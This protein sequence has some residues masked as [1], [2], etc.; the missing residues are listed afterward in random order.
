MCGLGEVDRE[1]L[2][3]L[4]HLGAEGKLRE[5]IIRLLATG[6]LYGL[7][8]IVL[9]LFLRKS[10]GRQV[11]LCALG[12]LVLSVLFGKLINQIVA[13]DRPFVVFPEDVRHVGLFVRP[14]SFPS[15][16]AMAGFGIA[17]G[18]LFGRYWRWGLIMVAISLFMIASRVAAGIHWPSDVVGGGLMGV[19]MA[20]IFVRIQRRYWPRLGLRKDAESA[21]PVPHST[22]S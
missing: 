19:G 13:R 11:L 1:V 2:F 16:H 15:I 8:G 18:V 14:A 21:S 10:G 22:G 12:S 9:Y 17:G 4:N 3:L 5:V 20:A 6:L 7:A